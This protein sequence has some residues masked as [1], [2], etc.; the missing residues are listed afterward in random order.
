MALPISV[1]F[2][3]IPFSSKDNSPRIYLEQGIT[4][5]RIFKKGS[6]FFV[7]N[8]QDGKY[9]WIRLSSNKSI[10]LIKEEEERKQHTEFSEALVNQVEKKVDAVNSVFRQLFSYLNRE[11]DQNRTVPVWRIFKDEK[12]IKLDLQNIEPEKLKKSTS[13]LVN[14]VENIFAGEKVTITSD[15]GSINIYLKNE[16]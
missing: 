14:D 11:Y 4:L 2:R 16:N 5:K 7:K 3:E 1:L 13:Y 10:S 6:S 12:Y 15:T 9:G 8:L